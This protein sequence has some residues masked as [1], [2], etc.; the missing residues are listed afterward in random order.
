MQNLIVEGT[1]IVI[2]YHCDGSDGRI[3]SNQVL[4]ID[5]V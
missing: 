1:M 2:C 3:N 5:R 4:N